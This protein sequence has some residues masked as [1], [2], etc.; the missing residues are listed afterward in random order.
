MVK[1]SSNGEFEFQW[2]SKGPNEGEFDLP[3]GVAVDRHG[4]VYVAD[5][6]NSRIQ[7]FDR[8]GSFVSQWKAAELGRPYAIDIGSDGKVYVVDGGDQPAAPPDR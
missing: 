6:S 1:F 7:I 2:G 3:H 4:Q 8:D 5:R